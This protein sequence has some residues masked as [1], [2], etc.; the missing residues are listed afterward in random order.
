MKFVFKEENRGKL[1]MFEN[2]ISLG[3]Y[4]GVAASMS[5]LGIRDFSGPFDWYISDFKGVVQCLQN[6]FHDFLNKKNLVIT[7][8]KNIFDDIKYNFRFNHEIKSNFENDYEKIYSKYMRRIE[9]FKNK[10]IKETCFIRAIK[11]AEELK[12][13]KNNFGMIKGAIKRYNNKNDVIY[14]V[15]NDIISDIVEGGGTSILLCRLFI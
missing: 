11:D 10:I 9:V 14:V 7:D 3:F 5:K 13:I 4:C 12:Y 6:D 15:S 8:N 2:F 1:S